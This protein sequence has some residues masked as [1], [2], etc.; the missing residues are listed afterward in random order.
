MSK[1]KQKTKTSKKNRKQTRLDKIIEQKNFL[2]DQEE[3]KD[4]YKEEKK[5]YK[6]DK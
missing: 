1:Q 3:E 4:R 6:P 2:L 5:G